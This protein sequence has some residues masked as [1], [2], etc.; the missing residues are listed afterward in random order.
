[1]AKF[2]LKDGQR[3]GEQNPFALFFCYST[4]FVLFLFCVS[5]TEVFHHIPLAGSIKAAFIF[6][7]DHDVVFAGIPR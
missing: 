4:N 3:D 1:M 6:S 2:I 5:R 7:D